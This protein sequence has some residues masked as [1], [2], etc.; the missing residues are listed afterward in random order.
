M[1]ADV[2]HRGL[3][4]GPPVLAP[5]RDGVGEDAQ[6]GPADPF[7]VDR[8]AV[9]RGQGFGKGAE[10]GERGGGIAVH[11]HEARLREHLADDVEVRYVPGEAEDPALARSSILEHLEH[12]PQIRVVVDRV[13]LFEPGPVLLH[14]SAR[15]REVRAPHDGRG[16]AGLLGVHGLDRIVCGRE[17]P[18]GF[19][20][21]RHGLAGPVGAE[22]VVVEPGALELPQ[23]RA[24]VALGTREQSVHQSSRGARE[25]HDEHGPV[26][27]LGGHERVVGVDPLDAQA[28]LVAQFGVFEAEVPTDRGEVGDAGEALEEEAE[29][30]A[31]RVVVGVGLDVGRRRDLLRTGAP[32]R[33]GPFGIA[34]GPGGAAERRIEHHSS[35]AGV[36]TARCP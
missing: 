20:P 8:L 35:H 2:D 32:V 1:I 25:T 6:P 24:P 17:P 9:Q 21:A 22:R 30:G 16:L 19:G 15:E 13:G 3:G 11:P 29:F 23:E 27:R 26:H 4:Q 14:R 34:A 31:E 10:R 28:V 36:L 12:L 33:Q 7:G 5:A 18:E